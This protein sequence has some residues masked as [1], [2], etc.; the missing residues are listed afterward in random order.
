MLVSAA[1]INVGGG[2]ASLAGVAGGGAS[3]FVQENAVRANNRINV[4]LFTR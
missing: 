4:N 3:L 1:G 2:A